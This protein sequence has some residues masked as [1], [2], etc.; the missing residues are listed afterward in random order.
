MKQDITN[1]FAF[2]D[3]FSASVDLYIS[4]NLISE[5]P[6]LHSPTRI[7]TMTNS[8]ILTIALLYH[9]SPCKNFKYFYQ[10]YLQLYKPEFPT[11]VSY[12]RFVSLKP[13]IL[14]YLQM[15]LQWLISLSHKT[16]ISFVDATGIAVCHN[17]RIFGNKVFKE[18][19][20]LGKTT[21]GW[22]YGFKLHLI[23]SDKGEIHGA[24]LTKGN[25]DD[26]VPV[27]VLARNL[28]GLLFGDKGYIKAELFSELYT[29]GLKLVTGIK[30]GMKNK[31]MIMFEKQMLRKR[32]I[33]ETVFDY[34][35][36]KFEL[37]HSRHR[38]VWNFL[39]HIMSTLVVYSMKT[40]KPKVTYNNCIAA[41]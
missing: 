29:K 4:H 10:S 19:A 3:D 9:K 30:K 14:G 20:A 13:R 41:A 38:S 5:N 34:L 6:K 27:P 8:E 36:N 21:K 15:L 12:E 35:K 25:V 17:K 11:L 28:T 24:K 1:L 23:I 18:F 2:I 26:R 39:V 31:P 32:S 37:E 40:T 22:F 7:P 16:G 33:I